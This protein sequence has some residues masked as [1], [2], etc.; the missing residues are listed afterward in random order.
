[1]I[2]ST[3]IRVFHATWATG[4]KAARRWMNICYCPSH[5]AILPRSV[6]I[7]LICITPLLTA[8]LLADQ[9]DTSPSSDVPL[10]AASDVGT[11]HS[12][13]GSGIHSE[14]EAAEKT[15]PLGDHY[16]MLVAGN[17][18]STLTPSQLT[19]F[20][21]SQYDGLAVRFL[22]QYDTTPVPSVQEMTSKLLQLKKSSAKDF[23]PWVSFN[24]MVGRDPEVD[25]P[26]GRDLYF[27]RTHGIDLED[28]AGAQRDFLELWQRSLHAASQTHAPGIIVDLELY[29]NYKAYDPGLLA[30]QIGKPVDQTLEL[31]HKLGIRMADAAAKEYPNGVM[32]FLLTDL[33]EYGWKVDNNVKY[34]PTPAYIVMGL[35]DEIRDKHY[36]LKVV[37]GGE[38]GLSYC[39]YSVEHLKHKIEVRANDFAPQLENYRGALELAGTMI[40]WPDRTSKTDFMAAGVCAKSDANTVEDQQAYLEILLKTYRYN[41]IYGTNNSGYDPFNA[42]TAPRFNAVIQKAKAKVHSGSPK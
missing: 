10:S 8:P 17:R 15:A 12:V 11:S 9:R 36:M 7:C 19:L 30:K 38:V 20:E 24:R 29:V 2:S 33:C 25:N 28:T 32:W 39:S 22:T 14:K 37:S 1:L 3:I 13:V 27:T 26:N 4:W 35:L 5:K 31:L 41:W 40:L 42:S 21:Q 18:A 34:Y 6:I 23:W 16:L